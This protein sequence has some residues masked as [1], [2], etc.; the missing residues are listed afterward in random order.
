MMVGEVGGNALAGPGHGDGRGGR[1]D[2]LDGRV[3]L[4]APR[5]EARVRVAEGH[6]RGAAGAGGRRL[7]RRTAQPWSEVD[8]GERGDEALHPRPAQ[9][10]RAA[11]RGVRL[12]RRAR[13]P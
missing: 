2:A 5:Q 9:R 3:D 10:P 12:P 4:V 6:E 7:A 13:Q 8:G 1:V 11:P